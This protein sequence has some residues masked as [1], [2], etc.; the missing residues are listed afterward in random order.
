LVHLLAQQVASN[1][2][3]YARGGALR[4]NPH[5]PHRAA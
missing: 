2:Q 4:G 5:L 3:A 1:Q